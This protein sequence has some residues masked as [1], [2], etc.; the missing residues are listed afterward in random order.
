MA[1]LLPAGYRPQIVWTA[2]YEGRDA[3]L[4]RESID[5]ACRNYFVNPE[6]M[7]KERESAA[8]GIRS[9]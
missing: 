9:F 4:D 7:E 6:D 1:P 3:V 8:K 2:R 5:R